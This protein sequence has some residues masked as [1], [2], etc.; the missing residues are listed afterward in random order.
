SPAYV[1]PHPCPSPCHGE[2]DPTGESRSD[3]I[4][5][6]LPALR[7]GQGGVGRWLMYVP[8]PAPPHVMGREIQP[9]KA[10]RTR[11]ETPSPQCGEGRV[12]PVAGLCASPPPPLP[13]KWRG[14]STADQSQLCLVA[15][16]TAST[17]LWTPSLRKIS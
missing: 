15:V 4:R 11:Y 13:M 9:V 12:G 2:G 10:G 5:N 3:Q 16:M 7:G 8:T 6:T 1:R 14:R 17:R